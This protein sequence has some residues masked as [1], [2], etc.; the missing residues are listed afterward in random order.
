MLGTPDGSNYGALLEREADRLRRNRR[1]YRRILLIYVG[2][3]ALF[4]IVRVS[5]VIDKVRPR[6]FHHFIDSESV[7]ISVM[8]TDEAEIRSNPRPA[9]NRTPPDPDPLVVTN[10]ESSQPKW[11]WDRLTSDFPWE[12]TYFAFG[13]GAF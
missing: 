13:V 9:V 1:L 6:I 11:H 12:T 4:L 8:P 3:A 2:L 5:D 7:E 10:S